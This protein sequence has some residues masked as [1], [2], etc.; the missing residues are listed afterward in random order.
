MSDDRRS[1]HA[2]HLA[3]A[4]L[5]A[6]APTLLFGLGPVGCGGPDPYLRVNGLATCDVHRQECTRLSLDG[7]TCLEVGTP[8]LHFLPDVCFDR[9]NDNAAAAC[10]RTFCN[11]GI[12]SRDV[13]AFCDA[14]VFSEH[15]AGEGVCTPAPAGRALA[16]V[17]FQQH[18]TVCSGFD[19]VAVPCSPLDEELPPEGQLPLCIDVTQ[20]PAMEQIVPPT[21]RL[22]RAAWLIDYGFGCNRPAALTFDV[23]PGPVAT[24]SGG[25]TTA[26]AIAVRGQVGITQSC[27]EGC[28]PTSVQT[29]RT[30]LADMTVAGT[31]IKQLV[32]TSIG[33]AAVTDQIGPQG[34]FLGIGVGE[35]TLRADGKVNGVGGSFTVRNSSPWRVDL[36][37]AFLRLRG[38]VVISGVGPNGGDVTI[39]ADVSSVPATPQTQAC[40]NQSSLA[41]LFG[42]EDV[43]TWSS[44]QAVLS[45][46]TA[47]LTQG[48]GALGI[49]GQGFL[50]IAGSTFTTQGL[51]VGTQASVDLFIPSNQP[52]PFWLGALQMFLSC[53]SGAVN[54]QY[55]GQVELT[56]KPQNSY[57]TLRFPLSA[58][59]RANLT[60]NLTDC[61]FSFGLNVNA[62]GRKWLLDKLR[63][64]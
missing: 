4:A 13:P 5:A 48:C 19:D 17:R 12:A 1:V 33:P 3:R 41:R 51:A 14:P 8:V 54:N 37:P 7:L 6:L 34:H 10:R 21:G 31:Q 32:V 26:T 63:L 29:F 60:R 23:S 47:P 62:T 56:G 9:N 53:P 46:V 55:I 36:S 22:S 11:D 35:L 49:E 20:T 44:S 42:F 39:N 61:S 16:A 57:S 50:P 27:G 28:L 30:D 40:A 59:V 45:L 25:G 43:G 15:L 38:G 58:A 24:A 18:S 2:G 52:N 64:Q